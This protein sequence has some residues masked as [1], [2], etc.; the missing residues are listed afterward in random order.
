MKNK[1]LD[2]LENQVF[3]R[4]VKNREKWR[5]EMRSIRM[6]N[7]VSEKYTVKVR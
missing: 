2:F 1:I 7:K 6:H 5:V 3:I 4:G